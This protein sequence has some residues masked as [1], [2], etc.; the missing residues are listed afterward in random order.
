MFTRV[1]CALAL[2]TL[3]GAAPAVALPVGSVAPSFTL[4]DRDGNSISLS[5]FAGTGV[6]LDFC[7]I[8]CVACR[9]FY[10]DHFPSLDGQALVVPVVIENNFGG[11]SVQADADIWAS[12]FGLSQALHMSGDAAVYAALLGDYFPGLSSFGLPTFFFLDANLQVVAVEEGIQPSTVWNAHVATIA[13]SQVPEPGVALLLG[14][15]LVA[16]RRRR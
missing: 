3:L 10:T 9:N 2:L 5:D 14:V 4:A 15:A 7:T 16:A 11:V 13:A 6:I 12:T 1:S 8:W